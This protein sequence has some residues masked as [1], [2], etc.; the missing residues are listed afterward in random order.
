MF[1]NMCG[2]EIADDSNVC[3]YCGAPVQRVQQDAN[4]MMSQQ[5]TNG[6]MSQQKNNYGQQGYNEPG[7]G[8]A[9]KPDNRFNWAA[10]FFTGLW[11]LV[12]GM[13]DAWLML[14]G[15]GFILGILMAIPGLNAVI[16]IVMI[17]FDF[18]SKIIFGRTGNYYYRLK[19]EQKIPF[20]KAI[21]DAQLRRF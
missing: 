21:R 11:L 1:C 7:Y 13:W 10:F 12:K 15:I 14:F 18:A 17:V 9:Y 20:R 2:K 16:G 6:M 4:G 8:R 5:N 19:E 3:G